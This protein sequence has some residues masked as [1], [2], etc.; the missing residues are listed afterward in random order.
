MLQIIAHLLPS[1]SLGRHSFALKQGK[2][3]KNY[4]SA[5]ISHLAGIQ[6]FS[7]DMTKYDPSFN[8]AP[9]PALG[10]T[11]LNQTPAQLLSWRRI[12]T[13][14]SSYRLLCAVTMD[15]EN[16]SYQKTPTCQAKIRLYALCQTVC[17]YA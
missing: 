4:L 6:L 9:N 3:E 16:D 13:Y 11:E 2:R 5:A 17:G 7:Y 8:A 15:L 12:H 10:N 1:L 14:S